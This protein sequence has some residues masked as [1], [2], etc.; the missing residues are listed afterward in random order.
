M[1]L[2]KS[3]ICMSFSIIFFYLLYDQGFQSDLDI[4]TI[5]LCIFYGVCGL[6][7]LF[8]FFIYYSEHKNHNIFFKKLNKLNINIDEDEKKWWDESLGSVPSLRFELLI[9][10]NLL[11]DEIVTEDYLRIIKDK[12]IS[13]ENNIKYEISELTNKDQWWSL[14]NRYEELMGITWSQIVFKYYSDS[15][16]NQAIIKFNNYP[17][18]LDLQEK[19][20][21]QIEDHEFKTEENKLEKEKNAEENKLEKEKNA[22]ENKLEKEKKA[23]EKKLEKEKKA[24]EKKLKKEKKEREHWLYWENVRKEKEEPFCCWCG[25]GRWEYL[26]YA[27]GEE[28]GWIWHFRNKDGSK[29]IRAKDNYQV[30]G[31]K[32]NWQCKNCNAK[33]KATHYASESPSMKQKIWKVELLNKGEGERIS[34]DW[35]SDE[36][37]SMAGAHH[38]QHEN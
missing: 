3:L 22:E 30:A 11:S 15:L 31:F 18:Y 4:L 32:S 21:K 27:D 9:K 14:N 35:K 7:F 37:V 10:N 16:S 5:L 17:E 24:E 8:Y 26:E 23:E 1:F 38:R 33:F 20:K 6:V 34:N 36:V 29:D 28:G 19:I 13:L 12:I 25:A 2:F